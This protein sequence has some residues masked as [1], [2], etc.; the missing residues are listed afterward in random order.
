M[1]SYGIVYSV[2]KSQIIAEKHDFS[3]LFHTIEHF[4]LFFLIFFL[5]LTIRDVNIIRTVLFVTTA[6]RGY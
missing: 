6:G 4:R 1:L 2:V 5:F 3:F